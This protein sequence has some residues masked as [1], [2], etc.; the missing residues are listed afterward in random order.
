MLQFNPAHFIVPT[1]EEDLSSQN[2]YNKCVTAFPQNRLDA[3]YSEDFSE[4]F[5]KYE[6][7]NHVNSC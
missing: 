1:A 6:I 5:D 2:T 3:I 4:L 7:F